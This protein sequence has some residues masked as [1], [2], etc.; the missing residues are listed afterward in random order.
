MLHPERGQSLGYGQRAKREDMERGLLLKDTGEK[1]QMP[2]QVMAYRCGG[3][4]GGRQGAEGRIRSP[5]PARVGDEAVQGGD[6]VG[7]ETTDWGNE[8]GRCWQ[9]DDGLG[10]AAEGGQRG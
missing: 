5:T 7:R 2:G 1:N 6:N 9:G 8:V 10:H 4:G 3:G